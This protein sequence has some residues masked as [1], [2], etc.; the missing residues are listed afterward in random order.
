MFLFQWCET[1]R[2]CNRLRLLDILVQPMQ[3]LTKYS[4]LLKAILK[5]TD[6]DAVRAQLIAMVSKR[7]FHCS[8]LHGEIGRK[9]KDR[10]GVSIGVH[11][12]AQ[13]GGV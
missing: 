13:G 9:V 5:K 1:Q 10:T 11:R 3:R 8:E 7:G 12:G 2:D 4:L 6:D